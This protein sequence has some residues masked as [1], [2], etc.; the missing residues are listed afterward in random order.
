MKAKIFLTAVIC[1]TTIGCKSSG[2]A[3]T[4]TTPPAEAVAAKPAAPAVA[5]AKKP[6]SNSGIPAISC[7]KADDKR[8][9]EVEAQSPKGCSLMY[10]KM[11]ERKKIAWSDLS[12]TH[13]ENVR[14]KIRDGLIAANFS[15]EEVK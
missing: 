12:S 14:A 10:T 9:I 8:L 1:A 6:V 3:S 5:D 15:C 7:V 2:T 4:A 11:G 13:C